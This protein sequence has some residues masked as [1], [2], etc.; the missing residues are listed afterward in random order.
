MTSELNAIA[1]QAVE[2][3]INIRRVEQMT[4]L[5]VY[6]LSDETRFDLLTFIKTLKNRVEFVLAEEIPKP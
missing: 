6:G 2:D 1:N 3:L 4:D 5:N